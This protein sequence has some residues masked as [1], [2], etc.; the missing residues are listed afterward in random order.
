MTDSRITRRSF[1]KGVAAAVAG[2]YVIS[3]TALGRADKPAAGERI[4]MGQ[5]GCGNRGR[6]VMKGLAAGNAQLVA[7]CDCYRDRRE[8]TAAQYQAKAYADFRELLARDDL[9]AVLVAVPEHWHAVIF[10]EACRHGKDVYCEKPLS[11]T[12]AEAQA[13]VAAARR[14]DRVTQVGTQQRS[15][16]RYRFAC[17]LVQNGYIGEVKSVFTE[18]GGT[19]R[20]CDLPGEPVPD[21]LDWDMWLGP[22]PWAPYHPERGTHLRQWWTWR[23]YSGGLMTDRGA[24]DFDVVQWGLGMDGSGPVEVFTPNGK[25]FKTLTYR[26]PNGVLMEAGQGGWGTDNRPHALVVFKGTEGE[27]SVWRGGIK[28]KPESLVDVKIKP[29]EIH[30]YESSNHQANFLDCVRS[31]K[32]CAADVAVGAGSVNVCHVG[33]IAYWLDRPLKWD[34]VKHAFVGDDQANRYRSRAMR[35]PWRL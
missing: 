10:V 5:I 14:Y 7:A 22:A 30:L 15:D 24:H 29:D 4:V 19:S 8:Q 18:P 32:P 3:S 2:P 21:G 9:D 1:V 26:Y 6:A 25:E 12:I 27:V 20:Y 23:D 16:G 35:A 11:Y 28:A 13:M 34:P 31:R 33:N 17:E